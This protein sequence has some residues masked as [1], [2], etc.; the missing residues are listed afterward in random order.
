MKLAELSLSSL[1]NTEFSELGSAMENQV[2]MICSEKTKFLKSSEF[3]WAHT[4]GASQ[5]QNRRS[6]FGR[7]DSS[8]NTQKFSLRRSRSFPKENIRNPPKMKLFLKSIENKNTGFSDS[9]HFFSSQ[10]NVYEQ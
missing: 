4:L 2:G 1:S 3:V 9:N 8:K 6:D 7:G 5:K 10:E